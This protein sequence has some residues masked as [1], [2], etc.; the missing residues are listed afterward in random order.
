[1]TYGEWQSQEV[2]WHE[3]E[4]KIKGLHCGREYH[5]YVVLVNAMG[6]SP[7]SEVLTVR[8]QG[9]RPTG[10]TQEAF[11]VSNTTY[12]TLKLDA[13]KEH[14]CQ[15]LYFVIEYKRQ[16]ADTWTTVTNDLLPQPR[17]SIRGLIPHVKYH[18]KVTAHNHAGSTAMQ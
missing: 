3:A 9:S 10:P 1:M 8:T 16:T 4:H 14:Q 13:W 15:I 12:F 7:T 2:G 6:S 11:V 18:V 17:Y 5:T